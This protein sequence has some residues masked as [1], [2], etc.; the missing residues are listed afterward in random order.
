MRT[1]LIVAC[2][3]EDA[4]LIREMLRR[5]GV[6]NPIGIFPATED[7]LPYWKRERDLIRDA[8]RLQPALVLLDLSNP[9]HSSFGL[10]RW[11]HCHVGN[12]EIPIAVLTG[13]ESLDR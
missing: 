1:V 6:E 12:L 10:L 2:T 11:F 13:E 5:I 3:E 9:H 7:L 8:K 4:L